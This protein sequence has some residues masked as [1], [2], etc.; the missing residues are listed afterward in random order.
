M[1][2]VAARQQAALQGQEASQVVQVSQAPQIST[3]A[4]TR[5][6]VEEKTVV[7]ST[8]RMSR[9]TSR[10]DPQTGQAHRAWIL[11]RRSATAAPV[12]CRILMQDQPTINRAI[13]LSG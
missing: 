8:N 12:Q 13:S 1:L 9:K 6:W 4:Q 7:V 2:A 11:G 3:P 10:V 5:G